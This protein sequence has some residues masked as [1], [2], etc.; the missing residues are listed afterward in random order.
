MIITYVFG[1]IRSSPGDASDNFC[2]SF[3]FVFF[4]RNFVLKINNQKKEQNRWD[5]IFSR[6]L[7][8]TGIS[9]IAFLASFSAACVRA[10]V[11]FLSP[12]ANGFVTTWTNPP[13]MKFRSCRTMRA[14]FPVGNG[15][16]RIMYHHSYE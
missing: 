8:E 14:T 5:G 3:Y 12:D 2:L 4:F 16:Y 7:D 13:M 9:V 10:S 1:R 11:I 6:A 15:R